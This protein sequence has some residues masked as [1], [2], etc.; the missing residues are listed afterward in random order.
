MRKQKLGIDGKKWKMEKGETPG[1]W[2][3]EESLE[4]M[5]Y[6]SPHADW[7]I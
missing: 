1:G 2:Q 6:W 5:F 4:V 7:L 3:L